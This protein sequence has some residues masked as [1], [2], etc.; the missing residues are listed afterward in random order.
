MTA[1][2]GL[3]GPATSVG[4]SIIGESAQ[5]DSGVVPV[6][7]ESVQGGDGSWI[8]SVASILDEL[9]SIGDAPVRAAEGT[10]LCPG[11]ECGSTFDAIGSE[12]LALVL[13]CVSLAVAGTLAI[14][15]RRRRS[16]TE[17]AAEDA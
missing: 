5:N 8:Q 4:E 7:S 15:A 3:F 13:I 12:A 1:S 17:P 6:N 14:R 16:S 2:I 11:S 9:A 10:S